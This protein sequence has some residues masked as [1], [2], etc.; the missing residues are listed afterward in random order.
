[1]FPRNIKLALECRHVGAALTG[2]LNGV[3][4][5]ICA[6]GVLVVRFLVVWHLLL[7]LIHIYS[8]GF[9][10]FGNPSALSF[11]L[12]SLALLRSCSQAYRLVHCGRGAC[13][14]LHCR[15]RN[16][17]G[18]ECRWCIQITISTTCC[19]IIFSVAAR[20]SADRR[21][22]IASNASN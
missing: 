3:R 15:S 13:A 10:T 19:T 9:A 8:P 1:L 21:V 16:S 7:M 6:C 5:W 12:F 4:G 17:V 14:Q 20:L 2:E 22:D 11:T 18:Y